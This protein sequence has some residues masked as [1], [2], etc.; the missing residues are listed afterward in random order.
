MPSGQAPIGTSGPNSASSLRL[1]DAGAGRAISLRAG[2][3][4]SL[5]VREKLGSGLYAVSIGSRL[6]SASSSASLQIG[7]VLRARVERSGGGLL[8][9]LDA[10]DRSV[11]DSRAFPV[12]DKAASLLASARLPN[13]IAGRIALAA[14]LGAGLSPEARVLGRVRLAALRGASEGREEE[15]ASLA[16]RMEEKGI[17]AELDAL[18]ELSALGDGRS[19][20]RGSAGERGSSGGGDAPRSPNAQVAERS[21]D[22]DFELEVSEEELPSVLGSLVRRI[23][24]HSEVSGGP[25]Q[26]TSS[27][28]LF[29]RL[30][31]KEGGWVL[32]PFRFSLGEVD[33]AG[34]FRIQLPY[35]RGGEGRFEAYFSAS[36]ASS[37]EDWSFFV[38][39]GGSR[40][41]SLRLV[42]PS[43]GKLSSA[44]VDEL[45]SALAAS[46]CFLAINEK[47]E[48]EG[49]S[50]KLDIGGFDADA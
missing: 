44:R 13:D 5:I 49:L 7:S 25:T 28:A 39:F 42:A 36:R 27:L 3:L 20:G 22:R 29:N 4:V 45:S 18:D 40:P 16:A 15:F 21:L 41:N 32:A 33:F 9:R 37:R 6:F 23:V 43:K 46:S 17:A 38:S 8:L 31:G 11:T 34:S 47:G 12:A 26:E 35:L 19:G 1:V 2:A 30:R 48:G 10:S 14:L 24:E 50:G